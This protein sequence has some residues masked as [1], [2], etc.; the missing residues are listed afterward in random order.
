MATMDRMYRSQGRHG[1]SKALYYRSCFLLRHP[2]RSLSVFGLL[3]IVIVVYR[4]TLMILWPR[5]KLLA[6]DVNFFLVVI[7]WQHVQ[8]T[9]CGQDMPPLVLN[10]CTCSLTFYSEPKMRSRIYIDKSYPS[11][12][13]FYQAT[14]IVLHA[15]TAL[16]C[17]LGMS[18]QTRCNMQQTIV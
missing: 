12:L 4:S 10:L 8:G 5:A 2:L 3:S 7:V 17:C 15:R 14:A 16:L 1:V 13:T 11:Y 9:S 6:I 18:L